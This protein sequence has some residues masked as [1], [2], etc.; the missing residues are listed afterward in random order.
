MLKS[1]PLNFFVVSLYAFLRKRHMRQHKLFPWLIRSLARLTCTTRFLAACQKNPVLYNVE[2]VLCS[3]S[4]ETW[5]KSIWDGP[6]GC[7]PKYSR[8]G[9]GVNMTQAISSSSIR[10]GMNKK[11]TGNSMV[12]YNLAL[13]VTSTLWIGKVSMPLF[14]KHKMGQQG[15]WTS[16]AD[17]TFEWDVH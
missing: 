10:C 4:I 16:I 5:K 11:E 3:I 14:T 9:I 2:L 13:K 15:R 17:T 8:Y 12:L 1:K 6:P 7:L